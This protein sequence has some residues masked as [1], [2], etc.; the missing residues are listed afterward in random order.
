MAGSRIA[1]DVFGTLPDGRAVERVVLRGQ[2]GFEARIITHGAVVQ[3][4]I[5]PDAKG[6]PD[7]VVLMR[8]YGRA[9]LSVVYPVSRGL[10]PVFVL[11][12]SVAFLG[13]GTSAGEVVGVALVGGGVVLVRQD[14]QGEGARAGLLLAVLIACLIATYTLVDRYGVRHATSLSYVELILSGPAVVYP[15]LAAAL[16]AEYGYRKGPTTSFQAG[17][18]CRSRSRSCAPALP[19]TSLPPIDRRTR[20][21]RCTTRPMTSRLLNEGE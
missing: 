9:D 10:A 18:R 2:G 6:A 14:G 7:D 16:F 5:A 3:A 12:A 8:A 4:L 13:F 15:L 1:K 17:R 11:C 21:G 20:P 19:C